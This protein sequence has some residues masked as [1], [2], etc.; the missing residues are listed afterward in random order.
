MNIHA[1]V[2]AHLSGNSQQRRLH[3][4]PTTANHRL[5]SVVTMIATCSSNRLLKEEDQS[6]MNILS[7]DHALTVK[8]KTK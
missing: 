3:T 2:A 1:A 7:F 4:A 6:W 5:L 8:S